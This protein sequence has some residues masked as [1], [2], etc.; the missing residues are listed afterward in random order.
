MKARTQDSQTMDIDTEVMNLARTAFQHARAGETNHLAWLLAAG[1]PVNLTNERGDSLLMLASYH[2]HQE[3]TRALLER[4]ADPERTNDRGQTPLAGAAFKGELAIARLLLDH[5]ARV[6]GAGPDG[7]TALMFAAM[8]DRL[9]MLELLLSRGASPEHKDVAGRTA[10]DYTRAMGAQRTAD[11][12]L[13]LQR[14][15]IQQHA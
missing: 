13:E 11:R 12:L 1:L 5:G 10:L 2:G 6:D 4:K 9:E 14:T 3:T 8:F 7:K 15:R